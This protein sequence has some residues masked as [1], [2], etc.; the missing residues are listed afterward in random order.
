M[1]V[2]AEL[3]G[4]SVS[5]VDP[6]PDGLAL[7][8]NMLLSLGIDETEEDLVGVVVMRELEEEV[9]N[10]VLLICDGS[11]DS[12][13]DIVDVLDTLADAE[14]LEERVPVLEDDSV[15]LDVPE[16]DELRVII[17]LNVPRDERV[18]ETDVVGLRVVN[19]LVVW[20]RVTRVLLELEGVDVPDFD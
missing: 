10:A 8:V 3:V 19:P 11:D 5:I 1:L 7:N 14:L 12:D 13:L 6:E 15:L 16:P 20:L 18:I 2:D 9:G 17:G 4:V